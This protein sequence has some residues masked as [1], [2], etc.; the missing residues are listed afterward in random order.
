MLISEAQRKGPTEGLV[1]VWM[2]KNERQQGIGSQLHSVIAQILQQQTPEENLQE[3]REKA[4][5][6]TGLPA[7]SRGRRLQA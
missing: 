6:C 1:C 4:L 2:S 5:P 7:R 3:A